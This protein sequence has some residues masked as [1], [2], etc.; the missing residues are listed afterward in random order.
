MRNV[1]FTHFWVS[2]FGWE[3]TIFLPEDFESVEE[4]GFN[5]IDGYVFLGIAK[6]GW[7]HILKGIYI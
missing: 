4:L 5:D 3:N 7:K 2:G 1:Q 6:N